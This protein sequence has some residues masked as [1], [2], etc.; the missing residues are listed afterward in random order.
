MHAK[1]IVVDRDAV[2]VGN[3]NWSP[4]AF[5]LNEECSVAIVSAG[6]NRNA[7]GRFLT[8]WRR[9]GRDEDPSPGGSVVEEYKTGSNPS[10]GYWPPERDLHDPVR[11]YAEEAQELYDRLRSYRPDSSQPWGTLLAGQAYMK[12]VVSLIAS[13]S[14]RVWVSMNG[15]RASS[16]SRLHPLLHALRA[17]A[18]RGVEVRALYQHRAGT[19]TDWAADASVLQDWG[20]DARPW[21]IRSRLHSR[22]ITVDG[23]HVVVGSVG[24]TPRSILLSEELSVH[25]HD[26][27]VACQADA[28]FDASWTST[29]NGRRNL[30]EGSSFPR[31][32]SSVLRAVE[33]RKLDSAPAARSVTMGSGPPNAIEDLVPI[34]QALVD[35]SVVL[36]NA[37]AEDE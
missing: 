5:R 10:R 29:I 2:V 25:I 9:R 27:E 26:P 1:A 16:A 18:D 21:P 37:Q 23:S 20:I 36:S 13:A 15:L 17:A 12:A 22:C 32:P 28:R 4:S 8:L 33:K 35:E 11:L 34:R 6:V 19:Q 14:E 30:D 24:W 7:A 31:F 3:S